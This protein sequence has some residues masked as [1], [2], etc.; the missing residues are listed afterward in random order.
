MRV[1][2]TIPTPAQQL[3]AECTTSGA[4]WFASPL[5]HHD[6]VACQYNMAVHHASTKCQY[7]IPGTSTTQRRINT[8]RTKYQHSKTGTTA[9][10]TTSI[11]YRQHTSTFHQYRTP[12]QNIS[13]M[14][15]FNTSTKKQYHTPVFTTVRTDGSTARASKKQQRSSKGTAKE[16]QKGSKRAATEQ[17]RS[18]KRTEKEQQRN[19][20]GAADEG[21]R[22]DG[23]SWCIVSEFAVSVHLRLSSDNV[24]ILHTVCTILGIFHFIV[25]V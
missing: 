24:T 9:R 10:R 1:V 17:Q 6:S 4:N 13:H 11:I 12:V 5:Q 25:M 19:S 21:H 16:Q 20:K 22:Q 15:Q 14:Y 2:T 7:D 18:S 8:T 23:L 3:L